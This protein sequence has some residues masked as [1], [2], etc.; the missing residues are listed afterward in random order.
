VRKMT[1]FGFIDPK[2]KSIAKKAVGRILGMNETFEWDRG[3]IVHAEAEEA[4]KVIGRLNFIEVGG[5]NR[6]PNRCSETG[7]LLPITPGTS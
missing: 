5:R 6:K 2:E 4:V 7:F 1:K 3:D